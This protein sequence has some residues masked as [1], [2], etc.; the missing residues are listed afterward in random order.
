MQYNYKDFGVEIPKLKRFEI[1]GLR[2]YKV[3][4]EKYDH[5]PPLASVT[6]VLSHGKKDVIEKWRKKVGD[7]AADNKMHRTSTNG[8]MFHTCVENYL[9][10]KEVEFDKPVLKIFFNKLKPTLHRINNI[11]AI[12]QSF[13]SEILGVAGTADIVAEF[14]GTLS[15]IDTKTTDKIKKREWIESYFIQCCVYAC[16]I[17]ELT[18]VMVKQIVIMMVSR[19]LEVEVFIEKFNMKYIK[20]FKKQLKKFKVDNQLDL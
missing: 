7:R 16:M 13:F 10:H 8:T 3:L 9:Q 20:E 4:G 19:D 18:G 17:Y 1:N 15:I 14:D 2:H 6:T 12:E 5:I 11:Y